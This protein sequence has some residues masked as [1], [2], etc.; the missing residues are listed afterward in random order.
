M[1]VFCLK[2]TK[3]IKAT[4]RQERQAHHVRHQVRPR[5]GLRRGLGRFGR[6]RRQFQQVSIFVLVQ[7]QMLKLLPLWPNIAPFKA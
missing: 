3:R 2:R 7:K 5:R 6:L 1:G 4:D